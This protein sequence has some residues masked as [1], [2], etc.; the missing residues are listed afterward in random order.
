[1]TNTL[2]GTDDT[3]GYFSIG[4]LPWLVIAPVAYHS[5]MGAPVSSSNARHI[6]ICAGPLRA[7]ALAGCASA[8]APTRSIRQP[9]DARIV[10]RMAWG[11]LTPPTWTCRM[12]DRSRTNPWERSCLV[13]AVGSATFRACRYSSQ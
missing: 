12:G 10:I 4:E 13:V 8:S 1:M 6:W 5:K 2:I 11:D 3:A 9:I 7:A